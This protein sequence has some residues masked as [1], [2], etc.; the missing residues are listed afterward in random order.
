MEAK[1]IVAGIG[2][3]AP[4]YILPAAKAAID[5]AQYL[6]G[7]KR[8]LTDFSHSKQSTH[9]IDRDIPAVLQ[10]IEAALRTSDV[11]VMVSGDPGF[12][13]FLTRLRAVFG[14]ER[15]VVIPGLSSLQVAFARLALPWQEAAF[16]SLH[17]NDE[18][19]EALAYK[20]GRALGLLL[21]NQTHAAIAAKRLLACGWPEETFT[22][23]CANLSYPDENVWRGALRDVLTLPPQTMCVMV[24]AG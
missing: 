7:G 21:D 20:K 11:V 18:S 17:G 24:V 13:S 6:V 5:A 2:P 22:G 1:I 8:A 16:L 4:E 19:D 9:A 23:V 14:P 15:L 3:G 12:H 10:F